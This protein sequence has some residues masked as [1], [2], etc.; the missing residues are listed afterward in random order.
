VHGGASAAAEKEYVYAQAAGRLT[1][2]GREVA[3]GYA[4]KGAGKNNPDKERVKNVG[5]IPRGVYRI[6]KPIRWKGMAN[7]FTLTPE[8]HD[9]HG[10]SGFLIHGDSTKHPGQASEGCIILSPAIR[11]KIADSGIRKLRVIRE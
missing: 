10:R 4:G 8:G 5:P 11:Q 3:T 9:A 6:G 2:D 1:L 7:V